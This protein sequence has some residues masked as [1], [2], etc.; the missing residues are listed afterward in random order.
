MKNLVKT[1]SISLHCYD[2]LL[3]SSQIAISLSMLLMEMMD[4]QPPDV[5]IDLRQYGEL[6]GVDERSRIRNKRCA[7]VTTS[8]CANKLRHL[9]KINVT[10]NRKAL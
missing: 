5:S 9:Q 1:C 8:E 6:T 10:P 3:S 7:T 4:D 2:I